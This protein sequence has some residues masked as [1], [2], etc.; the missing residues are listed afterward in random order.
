M[1]SRLPCLVNAPHLRS[2]D[3]DMVEGSCMLKPPGLKASKTH[4][5]IVSLP[6]HTV[7]RILCDRAQYDLVVLQM[8]PVRLASD[9]LALPRRR[10]V[11]T[12]VLYYL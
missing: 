10:Q 6:A 1:H 11:I 3:G 2:V 8:W 4:A 12:S 7:H 9:V 5:S